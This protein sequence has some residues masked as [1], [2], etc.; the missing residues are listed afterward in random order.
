MGLL[1]TITSSHGVSTLATHLTSL[2]A[3]PG[4]GEHGQLAEAKRLAA[5]HGWVGRQ[6]LR[7]GPRENGKQHVHTWGTL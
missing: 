1:A 7:H 3:E 5:P 4:R 6:D 2:M